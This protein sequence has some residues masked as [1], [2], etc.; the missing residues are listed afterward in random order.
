M[1]VR[2][3]FKGGVSLTTPHAPKSILQSLP[4]TLSME[5]ERTVTAYS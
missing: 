4:L 2:P 5:T 1:L 3:V